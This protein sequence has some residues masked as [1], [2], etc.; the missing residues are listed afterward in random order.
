MRFISVQNIDAFKR[1]TF[2]PFAS[3]MPFLLN[4]CPVE[5]SIFPEFRRVGSALQAMYE[6]FRFTESYG[7]IFQCNVKYCLGECQPVSA[8]S[9][10]R[11]QTLWPER[12]G[13]F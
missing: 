5:P 9:R 4:R 1:D 8:D 13:R 6:A 10:P 2:V 12:S 11:W 3:N 7:V